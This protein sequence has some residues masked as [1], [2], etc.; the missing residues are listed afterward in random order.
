VR[1][2]RNQ[3]KELLGLLATMYLF[4]VHFRFVTISLSFFSIIKSH[5]S[6]EFFSIAHPLYLLEAMENSEHH[7]SARKP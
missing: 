1:Q 5:Q 2:A 7:A 3:G 4:L 6:T